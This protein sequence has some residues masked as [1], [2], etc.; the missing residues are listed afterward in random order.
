MATIGTFKK[1]GS[2]EF[3][4]D[5]VTLSVQA[6]GVR[7]I[8]DLRGRLVDEHLQP[9]D[10]ACPGVLGGDDRTAQ[11]VLGPG[12]GDRAGPPWVVPVEQ[13]TAVHWTRVDLDYTFILLTFRR[14]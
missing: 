7:I 2:N 4:G 6:K 3:T 12:M 10:R 5:I 13:V 1:T 11:V 9:A 8:P 14:R